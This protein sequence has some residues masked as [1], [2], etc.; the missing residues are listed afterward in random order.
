MKS[1]DTQLLFALCIETQ[2]LS[3]HRGAEDAEESFFIC[4]EMPANEKV[5]PEI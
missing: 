1:Y 4:R 2:T 5:C 3:H